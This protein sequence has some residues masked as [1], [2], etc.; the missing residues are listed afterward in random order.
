MKNHILTS[1]CA[2]WAFALALNVSAA[3]QANS[4]GPELFWSL[5]T[6]TGELTITGR[7]PMTSCGWTG[8][9]TRDLVRTVSCPPGMTTVC[10]DAFHGCYRLQSVT[11]ND[12]VESIG[13]SAFQECS[14]MTTCDLGKGVKTIGEQ[15]F[16]FCTNLQKIRWSDC[17]ESIGNMAF[18][19][20]QNLGDTIFFPAS[21]TSIGSYAFH[22]SVISTSRVAVWNARRITSISQ[23][24]SYNAFN[25]IIFGDSVETIPAGLC[26]G[27]YNRSFI[28]P[29]TL[30]TIGANAFAFCNYVESIT[31]P[32]GVTS[33][34]SNA[35]DGCKSLK[36]LSIPA[37]LKV[38]PEAL[39]QNCVALDSIKLPE[40]ITVI[41][42]NAFNG[43]KSLKHIHLPNGVTNIG[44]QAFSNCALDTLV[45]P[46][47]LTVL[48]DKVFMNPTDY[49]SPT[50]LVLN[51]KL[52]ATGMSTFANW[53][54]LQRLTIGKNV[55]ILGQNCFQ[56]DSALTDITCYAAQPPL[57]YDATFD[58]VP[59]SCK[60]HVPSASVAAYKKA[61]YWSRLK[62][63]ALPDS[64]LIQRTVTVDAAETTADFTWPTD[65][66]AN[67][68][69]IDIYK[70][71]A[72]F[73]RL[74]LGNRGQLLGIA[75]SAPQRSTSTTQ[76]I[77]SNADQPHNAQAAQ[78]PYV[79]S[80]KVTGLDEATRYTFVLSALDKQGTPLHVYAGD[81]AT[82]GYTGQLTQPEGNEVLPTPPIIPGDPDEYIFTGFQ[83]TDAG[84]RMT[85]DE[86]RMTIIGGQLLLITPAGTYTL[87]GMRIR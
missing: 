2:V 16:I 87:S 79:L 6:G 81:F 5:D 64:A 38:L 25:I 34:G 60:L 39:C 66:A 41:P 37:G 14:A 61:Q 3:T 62:V 65:S 8:Y 32:E 75:F 26:R 12:S 80:F 67:S 70:N 22:T 29:A 31:I 85:N 9:N 27:L 7:G 56:G 28:L 10:N 48:G 78:L 20:C 63:T 68:Y 72:V 47:A 73:C 49:V 83:T 42:A 53:Q 82:T 44:N 86:C 1:L 74:T 52:I 19:D 45:L 43:C 17:L 69:Q 76:D 59:D 21:L 4:C 35:F 13:R 58:G 36:R 33:I 30:K 18:E 40:G 11:L 51:D 54:T 46:T 15:A 55:A 57:I 50:E 77:D 71:G 84:C 23:P 24:L